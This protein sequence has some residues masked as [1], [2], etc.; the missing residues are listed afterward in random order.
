MCKTVYA[1]ST[2][3]FTYIGGLCRRKS[4][5]W[6]YASP[7]CS[8][9]RRAPWPRPRRPPQPQPRQAPGRV[10]RRRYPLS[11]NT[12]VARRTCSITLSWKWSEVHHRRRRPTTE[13]YLSWSRRAGRISV[14]TCN[15]T[16]LTC[17]VLSRAWT[18]KEYI[19][20]TCYL[21]DLC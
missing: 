19:T 3:P 9:W 21:S 15:C 8:Y 20:E 17:S 2:G 6:W 11:C 10:P 13:N 1:E 12:S 5:S 16:S 4:Q 18:A 7:A 14:R